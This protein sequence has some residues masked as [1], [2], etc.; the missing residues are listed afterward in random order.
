MQI[1][2]LREGP[3]LTTQAQLGV[4]PVR[5]SLH[6]FRGIDERNGQ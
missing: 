1:V 2:A 3:G 5:G 6:C 4:R